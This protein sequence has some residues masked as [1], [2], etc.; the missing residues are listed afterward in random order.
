MNVVKINLK[1]CLIYTLSFVLIFILVCTNL[2]YSNEYIIPEQRLEQIKQEKDVTKQK[3]DLSKQKEREFQAEVN[4][5]EDEIN[6]IYEE[7]FKQLTELEDINSEIREIEWNLEIQRNRIISLENELREK[8]ELLTERIIEMYKGKESGFLSIFS[9]S[10]DIQDFVNKWKLLNVV[11]NKDAEVIEEILYLRNKILTEKA[12]VENERELYEQKREKQALLIESTEKKQSELQGVYDKKFSLLTQ[13]KKNTANLIYLLNQ[14]EAESRRIEAF[15]A[16]LRAGN[17][18]GRFLWPTV[19]APISSG[20]GYRSYPRRAFHYGIDIAAP[21]GSPIYAA[22]GGQVVKIVYGWGGGY[23]N[24]LIVYHGGGYTT[25]YAHCS[26]IVVSNGQSVKAGQVIAYMG[27]TGFSTG[28]H[29]HFEV[30]INGVAKN[31]IN[32]L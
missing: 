32:Y 17:F 22:A 23:G 11:A 1:K 3:I 28:S 27:S 10:I 6:K 21:Y 9:N 19:L 14:L 29:L 25:I 12:A 13:V 16:G 7:L 26:K 4:A 31:P 15:L 8:Y 2:A 18:S 20:F 30:R 24:Y 5:V